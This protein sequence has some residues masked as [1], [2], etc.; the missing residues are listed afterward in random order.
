VFDGSEQ[1]QDGQGLMMR[2]QR[3]MEEKLARLTRT[4]NELEKARRQTA[5]AEAVIHDRAV[6]I[7]V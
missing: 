6:R 4:V 2:R 5:K 3:A 7:I 1:D